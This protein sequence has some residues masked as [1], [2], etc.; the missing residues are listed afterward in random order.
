MLAT[1]ILLYLRLKFDPASTF[2]LILELHWFRAKYEIS[3]QDQFFK[4]NIVRLNSEIN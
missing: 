3:N 1:T 4:K 2:S